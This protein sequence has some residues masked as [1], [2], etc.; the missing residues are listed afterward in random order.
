[1]ARWGN[2]LVLPLWSLPI[3]RLCQVSRPR[4]HGGV[5]PHHPKLSVVQADVS[6]DWPFGL[7]L[8][9]P[10]CWWSSV[11]LSYGVRHIRA[12]KR[13]YESVG[14]LAC[15]LARSPAG[16]RGRGRGCWLTDW[17][18]VATA[19]AATV[20]GS[21][22]KLLCSLHLHTKYSLPPLPFACMNNPF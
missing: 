8:S 4:L 3:L 10:I 18:V 22:N 20:S 2:Q 16:L 1:M 21:F 19:S 5:R 6:V 7:S 14:S 12:H 13:L 11:G 17:L 15:S 9:S